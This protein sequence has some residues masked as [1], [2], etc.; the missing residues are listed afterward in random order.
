[1]KS[2][3]LAA[4]FGISIACLVLSLLPV[5]GGTAVFFSG[6]QSTNLVASA[7]TSDTISS[8]GYLFTYTRDKLFT[9]GVGLTNPVGRYVRVPWPT[10]LEAQAVTAGPTPGGAKII[11]KREDGEV[12]AVSSFTI[13]LLAN[14]AGAGAAIE[15]MPMSNGE[16]GFPDPV[17][18]DVT[19]YGGQSFTFNWP[20]LVQ[21]DTYQF[22]LYVDFALT[23]LT[24]TDASIP[25]PGLDA[26]AIDAT[27]IQISWPLEASGY[28]L[29]WSTNLSGGIWNSVTNG[30]VFDGFQYSV[31]VQTEGDMRFF[32]LKK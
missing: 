17:A 28:N 9:G 4:G 31:L 18:F 13:K 2:F 19:G 5:R 14:T 26:F 24:V 10:G 6:S 15:V 32:R 30:I 1:M 8:E 16:D 29:Q 3:R 23:A 11:V 20:S 12:F 27:N 25:P 22:S 21:F 7:L